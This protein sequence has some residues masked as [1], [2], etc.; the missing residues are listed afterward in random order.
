M[1]KITIKNVEISITGSSDEDYICISDI[2]KLINSKETK[3]L[4]Q[5]WMRSKDTIEF[6]GLWEIMNNENF[7]V[8]EFDAFRNAAGTNRFS[9]NP[10]SWIEKTNA[11]G[12]KTKRGRYSQGTFA[13][14]DIAFEF[15]SWLSPQIKLY[16]IKEFK[17]LKKQ[18]VEKLEWDNKRLITKLN[19]F[20]HTS[21]IKEHLL[22]VELSDLQKNYIYSSEADLLNVALFGVTAS[23]W[24]NK[25]QDKKG[26]LRDYA[27]IIELSIL[28]NLEFYNSKLI[29]NNTSQKDRLILL[30]NEAN[31]EK[32]LFNKNNEKRLIKKEPQISGNH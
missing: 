24:K 3:Y 9:I 25:N 29:A 17:R 32:I 14:H 26:N 30:N 27:T 10:S 2:A 5:N 12:I 11:I 19:Y 7:N 28:S 21:A 16:I 23:E 20:L 18:E 1:N 4:I 22:L 31:K 6:L 8:V 13:H 15:A